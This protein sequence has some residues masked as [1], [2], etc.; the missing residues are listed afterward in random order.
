MI[1][2]YFSI[3]FCNLLP[4]LVTT[5]LSRI[6]LCGKNRNLSRNLE[7][8][9]TTYKHNCKDIHTT[10]ILFFNQFLS[11]VFTQNVVIVAVAILSHNYCLRVKFVK[12]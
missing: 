11:L 2:N 10:R 7:V 4:E 3:E 9:L 5:V 1:L 12:V 8:K 6:H